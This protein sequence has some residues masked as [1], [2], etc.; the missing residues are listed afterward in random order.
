MVF[1]GKAA[2]GVLRPQNVPLETLVK[3]VAKRFIHVKSLKL[4]NLQKDL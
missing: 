4:N 2:I 3:M 1:R